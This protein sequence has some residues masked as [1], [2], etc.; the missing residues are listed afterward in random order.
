MGLI[1][2]LCSWRQI[3]P[4]QVT[5]ITIQVL[6]YVDRLK[7]KHQLDFLAKDFFH[8]YFVKREKFEIG[9][10]ILNARSRARLLVLD[11]SSNKRSWKYKYF[12]S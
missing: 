6:L 5:P 10:Y 8:S 2:E 3:Q 1:E 7:D 9:R 11:F 12:F 4:S